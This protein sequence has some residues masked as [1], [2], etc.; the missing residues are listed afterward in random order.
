MT[1]RIA[2]LLLLILLRPALHGLEVEIEAKAAILINAETGAVLF[3]RN[4]EAPH[5]PASITKIATALYLLESKGDSLDEIAV[6]S[7]EAVA[8]IS[9]EAKRKQQYR[10]PPHWLEFGACHIGLKKGEAMSLRALLHG[11]MLESGND[12]ANVIAEHL[13][14][15]VPAFMTALNARL[16]EIGCTHTHFLNPHGL[17]HPEH[18]TTAR[19][20]ARMTQWALRY[21]VFREV[22]K[23]VHACRPKTNLQEA[24][25]FSQY[26]KLIRPG[27]YH[28]PRAIGVKT[29]YTS[30]AGSTLVGAAQNDERTLI[31]VIL[32]SSSSGY[33]FQDAINL[34]EAA[35]AER[36]ITRRLLAAG[37]QS[38][39][40]CLAGA[41]RKLTS[42]LRQDLTLAYFPSEK[43]QLRG[44][45]TWNEKLELPIR[46][47]EQVAEVAILNE[48]GQCL[49]TAS[50]LAASDVD[51]NWRYRLVAAWRSFCLLR[52]GIKVVAVATLG[53]GLFALCRRKVVR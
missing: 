34:F 41:N 9:P 47:G 44:I 38:Y 7:P 39:S 45:L 19:D 27:K 22:V 12:A 1:P 18:V 43:P 48:N 11:L 3:E 29:G 33:R 4:A 32:D 46:E 15:S 40:R 24:T 21:P 49:A 36:K 16:A 8:A 17:H 25:S 6:A 50:L 53:I 20:M 37:R 23:S 52:H 13:A 5:Y 42:S 14:G 2:W 28:Y 31:A 26:N 30:D 10:C 35:F 51:L